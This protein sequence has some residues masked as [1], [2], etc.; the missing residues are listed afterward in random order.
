M[1][2]P[3]S[4]ATRFALA[5]VFLTVARAPVS[6]AACGIDW[7]IS[8]EVPNVALLWS[9]K[10]GNGRFVAAVDYPGGFL[11]SLDGKTWSWRTFFGTQIYRDITFG[12]NQF[13]AVGREVYQPGAQTSPD[14]INWSGWPTNTSVYDLN[15]VV[16]GK[17]RFVA[18]GGLDAVTLVT[19]SVDGKT[20]GTP[21]LAGI[22]A[23]RSVAW[24]G[25]TFVAVGQAPVIPG[26][27]VPSPIIRSTDGTTWYTQS[28][29]TQ[30]KLFDVA[31]GGGKFV[32]VGSGSTPPLTTIKAI[33]LTSANGIKWTPQSSGTSSDLR[34]VAWGKGQYVAV[35]VNGTILTSANG[36]TWTKRVSK[37]SVGLSGVT[38]GNNRF[39]AVGA[40]PTSGTKPTVLVSLCP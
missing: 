25:S 3:M 36:I 23:L 37:T 10:Y 32:A 33:I 21:G 34:S 26:S 30:Q 1:A 16:Y 28:S 2:K 17:N 20:W 38:Y 35:G 8:S 5:V 12:R 27:I 24:S 7:Q 39:V 4:A 31:W 22:G 14:G 11:V 6:L 19:S 29:G 15:G 9:V 40:R 13:L 18:V